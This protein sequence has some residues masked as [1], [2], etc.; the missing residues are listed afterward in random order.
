MDEKK[1][2]N[3]PKESCSNSDG[4]NSP[5]KEDETKT[6]NTI[7]IKNLLPNLDFSNNKKDGTKIAYPS[8]F[9]KIQE[10][11]HKQREKIFKFAMCIC[12]WSTIFIFSLIIIQLIIRVRIKDY[13]VL[14]NY[15]LEIISFAIILQVF[16]IIKIITKAIWND[17]PYINLIEK[18]HKEH[19]EK[20][21]K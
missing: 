7:G 10:Q 20:K 18:E 1:T 11:R 2:T 6:A 4:K 16:L 3:S 19:S 21:F 9:K 5:N 8:I 14:D 15:Q 13:R 17:T 12:K